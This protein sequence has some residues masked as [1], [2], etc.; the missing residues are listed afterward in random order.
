MSARTKVQ[1]LQVTIVSDDPETLDG[2]VSY[3][4]G[5]GVV[6]HGTRQLETCLGM[7]P[8]GDTAIVLFPDDFPKEA[9]F[10]TLSVFRA[11]CPR[12]LPVLVTREPRLFQAIPSVAGTVAPFV[13]L[14]PA[15]GWAILDAVRSHFD[16]LRPTR[17]G[18]V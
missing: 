8:I 4:R 14:R 13:V 7:V 12:A 1:P 17:Q 11:V 2:L 15:W 18:Y 6:T 10:A 3:F 5:A 9:V 16:F